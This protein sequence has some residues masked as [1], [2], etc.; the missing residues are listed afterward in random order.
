MTY[1]PTSINHTEDYKKKIETFLKKF[2]L[3]T[4]TEG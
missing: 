4:S 2:I 3:V 1:P